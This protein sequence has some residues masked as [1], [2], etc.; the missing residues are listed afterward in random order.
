MTITT[1][2]PFTAANPATNS[3]ESVIDAV[4]GAVSALARRA[5]Q[6]AID[7]R[8]LYLAKA[9]DH[10]DCEQRVRAWEENEQRLR[11]LPPVL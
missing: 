9:V 6:G 5:G 10:A 11:Q 2:N 7:P 8:D 1:S 3:H 4:V